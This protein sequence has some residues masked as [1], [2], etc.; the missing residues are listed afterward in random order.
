MKKKIKYLVIPYFDQ[1]VVI[2][3]DGGVAVAHHNDECIVV[4]YYRNPIPKDLKDDTFWEELDIRRRSYKFLNEKQEIDE[5]VINIM[6]DSVYGIAS[7]YTFE[8]D[9]S[10]EDLDEQLIRNFLNKNS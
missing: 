2:V 5:E 4:N 9:T 7:Q 3:E 6:L 8:R 1:I 10:V